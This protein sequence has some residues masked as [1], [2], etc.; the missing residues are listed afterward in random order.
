MRTLYAFSLYNYN[1]SVRHVLILLPFYTWG[2]KAQRSTQLGNVQVKIR[3]QGS[4]ALVPVGLITA[5]QSLGPLCNLHSDYNSFRF[6]TCRLLASYSV[7][8]WAGGTWSQERE[9][10]HPNITTTATG[11]A[12]WGLGPR[13][14]DPCPSGW[15]SGEGSLCA[16]LPQ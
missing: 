4:L 8:T 11:G 5:F 10:V 14:P 2:T 13:W 3:T 15:W 9:R 1:N 16:H 6:P 7:D 12:E